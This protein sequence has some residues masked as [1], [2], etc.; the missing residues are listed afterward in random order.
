[1]THRTTSELEA[2]VADFQGSPRD[3]G[4][5]DLI[6]RR[7][8]IGERETLSEG[9]L[10]R[11]VGLVGDSWA[12]RASSRTSDGTAHPD[13]QLTLMNSRVV[14]FLAGDPERRALA[15]D[16]LFVDLDLGV[17]NLPA[18]TRLTFE[19]GPDDGIRPQIEVTAQPHTGCAK[20]VER[21]GAEAMAFVNG[22]IGRPLRLRGLN[23]RV[24][25]PGTIRVGDQLRVTRP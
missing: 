2:Q 4:T 11:T 18:G 16:Q 9:E 5:L 19:G 1:M 13:M 6:V 8:A 12:G 21:F 20:F 25:V 14:G 24:I 23:A 7:P 10:D 17:D 3:V 15:G 22:R